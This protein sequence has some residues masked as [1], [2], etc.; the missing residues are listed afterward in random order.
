MYKGTMPKRPKV[1]KKPV[2]AKE[3]KQEEPTVIKKGRDPLVGMREANVLMKM[4]MLKYGAVPKKESKGA[5]AQT[6]KEGEET[7]EPK[8]RPKA[9]FT[10]EPSVAPTSSGIPPP[11][12]KPKV[13]LSDIGRPTRDPRRWMYYSMATIFF[14]GGA[15]LYLS[16][17]SNAPAI[18]H[19]VSTPIKASSANS[20]FWSAGQGPMPA[21]IRDAIGVLKELLPD[22]VTT[23]EDDLEQFGG[24]GII[25]VGK[26]GR[27]R[28]VVYPESTEDVKKIMKVAD[29]YSVP[30]IPYSG[31]TS[32]EG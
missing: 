4:K 2:P 24:E 10:E 7:G 31:G 30:V 1:E 3:E 15:Y 11:P 22:K 21:N 26:G 29:T 13:K 23:E 25:G 14:A 18:K 32:L 9:V 16:S 5:E 8:S 12:S 27:P 19:D 17:P 20:A 6:P 28:A